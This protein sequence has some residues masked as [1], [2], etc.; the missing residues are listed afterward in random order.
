MFMPNNEILIIL[1]LV[2]FIDATLTN[3]LFNG[4]YENNVAV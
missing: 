1:I 2:R 4:L 3:A